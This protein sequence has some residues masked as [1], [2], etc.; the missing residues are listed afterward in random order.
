R[1]ELERVVVVAPTMIERALLAEAT[2]RTLVDMGPV[3]ARAERVAALVTGVVRKGLSGDVVVRFA[4]INGLPGLVM[5]EPGGLV[6]TAA[7]EIDDD[8]VKAI[9]IVRNPDKVRHVTVG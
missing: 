6:Q 4:T 9:Y 1:I 5:R 2:E 3:W 7:F 8:L